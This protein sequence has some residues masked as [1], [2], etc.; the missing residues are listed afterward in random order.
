MKTLSTPSLT[1]ISSTLAAAF[2]LVACARSETVTIESLLDEMVDR[3]VIARMPDPAYTCLQASSYNRA[4]TAPDEPG[5]FANQD[6][7]HFIRSEERNGETEWVM[8]DAAGPGAVVRIWMPPSVRDGTIVGTVRVY[9]D[10]AEEPTLEMTG[11][12]LLNGGLTGPPLSAVRAIGR[13]LYLPIPYAEHCKI[14]YDRNFWTDGRQPHDRAFYLIN[15]RSYAAGTQVESFSMERL[16]AAE[17]A[18]ERV[19][20][21]LLQPEEVVPANSSPVEPASKTLKAGERLTLHLPDGPRAVGRFALHLEADDMADALRS[22]VVAISFDGAPTVWCP[23]GDFFGT[24]PG[25]HPWRG[26]YQTVAADGWMTSYWVMP[27]QH[28]AVIHVINHGEQD[29]TA[30]LRDVVTSPWSWDER[31]L[32]FHSNFRQVADIPSEP[33]SDFNY[34]EITGQGMYVGDTLS[35]HHQGH[36]WWG[37]GDERIFVDGEAFPSHAGTGA[38]DYYGFAHGGAGDAFE[39]PFHAVPLFDGHRGPGHAVNNRT[40]AL[41]AI[42]FMKSLKMDMEVS[43]TFPGV[44]PITHAAA[45]H[46][47]AKPGATHN[48][49]PDTD[50]LWVPGEELNVPGAIR[51]TAPDD[52][53][54]SSF[55][56]AGRWSVAAAPSPGNDYVINVKGRFMRTPP[57]ASDHTFAG[58]SLTLSNGAVI[59]SKATSATAVLTVNNLIA[60]DGV[61]RNSRDHGGNATTIFAGNINIQPDGLVLEATNGAIVLQS[62]IS[63]VG[64]LSWTSGNASYANQLTG[65]NTYTGDTTLTNSKLEFTSTNQQWFNIQDANVSNFIT[66]TGTATA[67]FNGVFHVSTE[68][69]T[70]TTGTWN[71]VDVTTINETWGSSFGLKLNGTTD[72]ADA[73]G[74]VYT[75]TRGGQEW[76]F[77]TN[78][79]SLTLTVI[80]EP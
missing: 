37:E 22:T 48:R 62:A 36:G 51:L 50:A 16:A 29:V 65:V 74:G 73:G 57:N 56:A 2:M 5:W 54:A 1:R 64:A 40:R 43:T 32:L 24:G 44:V 60:N 55:N 26:W 27:Y 20:Q 23:A 66:G 6:W 77:N 34:I 31:S 7:S 12:Q 39:A 13:N 17:P 72:F 45:T 58:D 46:W 59:A 14:T 33:K 79:G 52:V 25:L 47:Y 18:I 53:G 8:M 78:T 75:A 49:P 38:E 67:I 11:E 80:P 28:S 76:T 41:D 19:Q 9:L 4:Q 63:G 71:L 70:D 61:L 3:S 42:P 30:S 35:I 15:Y 10:H 69:L 21:L 68:S